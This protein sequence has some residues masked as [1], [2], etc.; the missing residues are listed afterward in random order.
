M[1]WAILA[2]VA[3][4]GLYLIGFALCRSCQRVTTGSTVRIFV[5][6]AELEAMRLHAT[7]TRSQRAWMPR[8]T[9]VTSW[10]RSLL[11]SL[12]PGQA[13]LTAEG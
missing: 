9:R 3:I 6:R 13:T 5:T 7:I 8:Q 10:A 11:R 12:R 4:L 2:V 1:L